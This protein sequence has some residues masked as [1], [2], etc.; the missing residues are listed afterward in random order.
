MTST[1]TD[2]LSGEST[3]GAEVDRTTA[4]LSRAA[5]KAPCY[6][7]T[8]A[9]ITLSGLQTIDG[10]DV[11]AGRRV[12][13]K[14]QVD[15]TQNSIR[16][17]STGDW[18]LAPDWDDNSDVV[19]GT[20]V[21][22]NHGTVGGGIW[23]TAGGAEQIIP[24]TTAVTWSATNVGPTGPTGPAPSIS[25]GTVTTLAPGESA[26]V[27]VTGTPEAVVLN[28]SIPAGAG[29]TVTVGTVTTVDAGLPATVTNVGT[30]VDV[31]LDFE[32]PRGPAGAG[33]GDMLAA[34]NLSELVS[35]PT[36]RTNLGIGNVDN[37]SDANKPVST[38]TQ[39]AL[40]LKQDADA[41]LT[42][43]AGLTPSNDDFMQRKAGAWTNR[44]PAQAKTDLALVKADVGLGNVDDTSDATKNSA[45]A[46]LTNKRVTPRVG[47]IASSGTPTP[48]GD[49]NDVFTITALAAA[50]AI[51]APT[52]TP[53]DGQKLVMRIKDNGTARALTWNAIYRALATTLPVTTTISKT[54][55][56]G[57]MYN[58][59]D[60]KWDLV[61]YSEEY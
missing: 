46:T 34:N 25:A 59:A 14:N 26:V 33:S 30:A 45:T 15:T 28:F 11:A 48:D 20:Q 42:A 49:A 51:A 17:A 57:F 8:T 31:I 44:T 36:S 12:L 60:T 2:R 27:D 1:I 3:A 39:T 7:A 5:V 10:V 37:T 4:A 21:F 58:S 9:A 43:I 56:L 29:A 54:I 41:D 47:T 35:K 22:V 13:V 38:A 53:T 61:A 16:I 18:P 52:G 23:Y 32:L 19:E 55:Y 24:G 40:D 6:V 50:A